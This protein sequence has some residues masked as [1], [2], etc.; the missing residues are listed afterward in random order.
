MEGFVL[1]AVVAI[2]VEAIIE[3]AKSVGK[4]F[5][6]GNYRTAATQLTAILLAVGLC[7]AT[8]ADLFRVLGVDFFYPWIG[9]VLTGIFGSRGANYVS[10]LIRRLQGAKGE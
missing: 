3:Y 10:D 7:G 8:G 9:V 1:I 6:E 4:L 2:L 5:L